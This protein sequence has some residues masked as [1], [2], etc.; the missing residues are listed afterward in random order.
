MREKKLRRF[1]QILAELPLRSQETP[2]GS[3]GLDTACPEPS[4]PRRGERKSVGFGEVGEQGGV[5]VW[6]TERA[7][8]S[9]ARA[10]PGHRAPPGPPSLSDTAPAWLPLGGLPRAYLSDILLPGAVADPAMRLLRPCGLRCHLCLPMTGF[11]PPPAAGRWAVC[12]P[13]PCFLRQPLSLRKLR[14]GIR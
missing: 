4:Y 12:S 7:P 14:A 13:A 1:P 11:L 8:S 9:W 10:V 2:G 3:E 5:C 6:G